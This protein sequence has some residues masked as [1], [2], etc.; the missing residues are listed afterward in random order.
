VLILTAKDLTGQDLKRL[1]S[2]NIQQLVQKGEVDKE[3]LLIKI[4]KMLGL[5]IDISTYK[6]EKKTDQIS[7]ISKKEQEKVDFLE[8]NLS[9][10]DILT[11]ETT[12]IKPDEKL[13]VLVDEKSDKPDE[14][15]DEKLNVLVDEK[16]DKPDEKLNVLVIED[17]PDNMITVKAVLQNKCNIIEAIDGEEGYFK[18][19]SKPDLIFLDI[20]LP[21]MDGY[22]VIKKI[23]NNED[24]CQIPVVGMTAH[25][26]KGDRE[27]IIASGC[28]GYMSK[29]VD[30]EKL[31]DLIEQW[32][33]RKI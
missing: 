15:S 2:N 3:E 20:S 30:P 9:K 19:L 18:A 7:Y 13:N 29:P 28:D 25:A 26:M 8:R 12:K 33:K 5:E 6:I 11:A 24:I 27:K 22:E 10:T 23:R 21:K 16:S 4:K 14:K 31:I 1:S 17:N 32:N